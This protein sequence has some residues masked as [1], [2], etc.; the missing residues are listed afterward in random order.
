MHEILKMPT[1]FFC[2]HYYFALSCLIKKQYAPGLSL[3]VYASLLAFLLH[4]FFI[5]ESD[6]FLR[7]RIELKI[8]RIASLFSL[9]A[10]DDFYTNS[11][12]SVDMNA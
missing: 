2:L 5:I 10:R 8:K 4:E 11:K 1:C 3:I 9:E 6:L 7:L 12:A